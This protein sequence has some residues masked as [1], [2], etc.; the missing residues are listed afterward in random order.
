MRCT[1]YNYSVQRQK[2]HDHEIFEMD[3]FEFDS[4]FFYFIK[5]T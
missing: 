4:Y 3:D 5:D 1:A 2:Y